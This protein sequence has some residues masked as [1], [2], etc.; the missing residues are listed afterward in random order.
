MYSQ[1]RGSPPSV[2]ERK[3]EG[4]GGERAGDST[5]VGGAEADL[6]A[7]GAGWNVDGDE[8]ERRRDRNSDRRGARGYQLAV[9]ESAPAG[10][11]QLME[12]DRRGGRGVDIGYQGVGALV[13]RSGGSLAVE[14]GEQGGLPAGR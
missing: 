2:R 9:D 14:D 5:E 12:A 7:M 13:N 4:G 11:E 6:D 10:E 3:D 1:R 8:A